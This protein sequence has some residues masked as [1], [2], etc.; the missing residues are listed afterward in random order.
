MAGYDR[1]A[2]LP[3]LASCPPRASP[4][5]APAILSPPRRGKIGWI[6]ARDR[7]C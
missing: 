3:A 5:Y 1:G 6:C 2:P 7:V 4:D